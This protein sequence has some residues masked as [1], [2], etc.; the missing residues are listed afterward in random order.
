MLVPK[1]NAQ[2]H[3]VPLALSHLHPRTAALYDEFP[4]GDVNSR[5]P[6][7]I[8]GGLPR[9]LALECLTPTGS[10]RNLSGRTVAVAY[11]D[12]GKDKFWY[13][14]YSYDEKG[15]PECEIHID[16][17][18]GIGATYFTYNDAGSPICI[19][20][21]DAIR[22]HATWYAYDDNG[23]VARLWTALSIVGA[24]YGI[25]PATLDNSMTANCYSAMSQ[26][27]IARPADPDVTYAYDAM[28]RLTGKVYNNADVAGNIDESLSYNWRLALE[29]KQAIV[30]DI[31]VKNIADQTLSYQA[32][33]QITVNTLDGRGANDRI[34]NETYDNKGRLVNTISAPDPNIASR[35]HNAC[36]GC[37]RSCCYADDRECSG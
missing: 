24:Q 9:R 30:A 22:N 19:R 25:G 11:R 34:T 28:G 2:Q 14:V 13:K 16:D 10:F 27:F 37:Q 12:H 20:Q 17:N 8:W 36:L 26:Y 18:L 3:H 31:P 23:R 29:R 35:L 5:I 4:L 7:N 33:M 1:I 32:D 21:V 15:R 6:G